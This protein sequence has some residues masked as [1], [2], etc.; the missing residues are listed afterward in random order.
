MKLS[1]G[2]SGSGER[3]VLSLWVSW[4]SWVTGSRVYGYG[5]LYK[6]R[7]SET[8]SMV[9]LSLRYAMSYTSRRISSHLPSVCT[10]RHHA[11]PCQAAIIPIRAI[12]GFPNL[13]CRGR[14]T[15]TTLIT[16]QDKRG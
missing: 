10:Q 15:I 6:R 14:W 9:V 8:L 3:A 16:T 2:G 12:D 13:S 7:L 1:F 4:V 11:V 5:A